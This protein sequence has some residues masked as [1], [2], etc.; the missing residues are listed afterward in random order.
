MTWVL[1]TL[2]GG[3]GSAARFLVDS[4]VAK[5]N[6]LSLPAGTFAVNATAC[7]L[8]GLLAGWGLAHPGHAGVNAVLGVGLLGGYSTFS[9]ASVEGARLALARRRLAA[10]AQPLL[11]LVACLAA[12]ALGIVLAGR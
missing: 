7:F 9:T 2:A 10:V 5:R 6:R 11:M 4:A 8:L 1:L 3:L 12:A